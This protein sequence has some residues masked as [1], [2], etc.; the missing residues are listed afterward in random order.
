[1]Q[2]QEIWEYTARRNQDIEPMK[3]LQ[4]PNKKNQNSLGNKYLYE[5]PTPIIFIK[6]TSCWWEMDSKKE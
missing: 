6:I 5:E 4:N 1:M 3:T 2:G